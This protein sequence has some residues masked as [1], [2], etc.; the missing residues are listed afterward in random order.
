MKIV[1]LYCNSL[2]MCRKW[3]ALAH[4]SIVPKSSGNSDFG[5]FHLWIRYFKILCNYNS[6]IR[7][8]HSWLNLG[9]LPEPFL[10]VLPP[11]TSDPSPSLYIFI[12]DL[13][14]TTLNSYVKFA[15][16]CHSLAWLLPFIQHENPF[17]DYNMLLEVK[18][19]LMIALALEKIRHWEGRLSCFQHCSHLRVRLIRQAWGWYGLV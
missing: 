4:W 17:Q 1:I 19:I 16:S 6:R 10:S 8:C 14:T 11:A 7:S 12:N 3:R 9:L 2:W 13:I 5:H 15:S 18:L